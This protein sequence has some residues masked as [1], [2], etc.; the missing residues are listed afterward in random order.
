MFPHHETIPT[1]VTT[2][3][4]TVCDVSDQVNSQASNRARLD[5]AIEV[6]LG[7]FERIEGYS[8]VFY[9][10]G[11]AVLLKREPYLDLVLSPFWVT[12]TDHIYQNFFKS[13]TEVTFNFWGEPLF[14]AEL[15]H[16]P[17]EAV[18]FRDIV[19]NDE[20]HPQ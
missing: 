1:L 10:R 5:R 8:V 16:I 6:R 17:V 14:F 9:C 20:I 3:L 7:C 11:Y 2:I 18:E 12:I 15:G 19:G 13:Q 4:Q